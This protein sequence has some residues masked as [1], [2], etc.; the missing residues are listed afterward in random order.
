[1]MAILTI[2]EARQAGRSAAASRFKAAGQVLNERAGASTAN[3]PFHVFLSHSYQDVQMDADAILGLYKILSDAGI[4]VYVDWIVDCEMDRTSVTASTADKLRARMRQSKS[5][6]F[7]T[8]Q[9]SGS[10]KWMPWELGFF[11]GYKS[12]AA[13]LPLTGGNEFKGQEYLGI[14]PYVDLSNGRVYI[15]KAI[16]VWVTFD[17]WLSGKD[18]YKR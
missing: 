8:S 14:Y 10:S 12:R 16:G 2:N 5:L 7:A 1:M 13:I 17:E 11:D 4:S 3:E 6:F 15:Q 18:P 9:T